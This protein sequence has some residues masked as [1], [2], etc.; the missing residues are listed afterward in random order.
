MKLNSNSSRPPLMKRSNSLAKNN[1]ILTQ[2]YANFQ[3]SAQNQNLNTS[4]FHNQQNSRPITSQSNTGA[5][6]GLHKTNRSFLQEKALIQ[7]Q[8]NYMS[9]SQKELLM[10][11]NQPFD[12][13]NQTLT[14]PQNNS[15]YQ[16]NNGLSLPSEKFV[17][18]RDLNLIRPK[19]V[20]QQ[21]RI[22]ILQKKQLIDQQYQAQNEKTLMLENQNATNSVGLNNNIPRRNSYLNSGSQNDQ[23]SIN[24]QSAN[25]TQQQS[26][27][28]KTK[29][30]YYQQPQMEIAQNQISLNNSKNKAKELA[31]PDYRL[32]TSS[33]QALPRV[34]TEK[35]HSSIEEPSIINQQQRQLAPLKSSNEYEFF[36]DKYLDE[37]GGIGD[38]KLSHSSINQQITPK[39]PR[40]T[41]LLQIQAK[42]AVIQEQQTNIYQEDTQRSQSLIQFQIENNEL[43]QVK[44]QNMNKYQEILLELAMLKDE[45]AKELEELEEEVQ[46]NNPYEEIGLSNQ[47]IQ[48]YQWDVRRSDSKSGHKQEKIQMLAINNVSEKQIKAQQNLNQ[49]RITQYEKKTIE[50][51]F[52]KEYLPRSTQQSAFKD[53]SSQS[54]V[55]IIPPEIDEVAS[56]ISTYHNLKNKIQKSLITQQQQLQ[57]QEFEEK[58]KKLKQQTSKVKN[59]LLKKT[60]Q[61][62]MQKLKQKIKEEEDSLK[63]QIK[64]KEALQRQLMRRKIEEQ[65]KVS[66]AHNRPRMIKHFIE[67][68][69]RQVGDITE[70]AKLLGITNG[71]NLYDDNISQT[72]SLLQAQDEA[73]NIEIMRLQNDIQGSKHILKQQEQLMLDQVYQDMLSEK[74]QTYQEAQNFLNYYG[75]DN[76]DSEQNSSQQNSSVNILNVSDQKLNT[77]AK[78]QS[79]IA[80]SDLMMPLDQIDEAQKQTL[81][82]IQFYANEQDILAQKLKEQEKMLQIVMRDI[83]E[84]EK[85]IGY[86]YG[87]RLNHQRDQVNQS[88]IA[89]K[90]GMSDLSGMIIEEEGQE[91]YCQQMNPTSQTHQNLNFMEDHQIY[92]EQTSI[93]GFPQNDVAFQLEEQSYTQTTNQQTSH[94]IIEQE[95]Q[96]METSQIQSQDDFSICDQFQ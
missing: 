94:K 44:M 69:K 34:K 72:D 1:H 93:I 62:K 5:G 32:Q 29:A 16:F 27:I 61:V 55:A 41:D 51:H 60:E 38:S 11:A 12:S 4:N 77:N 74:Y 80:Q 45:T 71:N 84:R 64:K 23:N 46:Q 86:V 15:F 73:T 39:P 43:A 20:E 58:Q 14:Q 33:S 81:A 90:Q 52:K 7:Q 85:F 31:I 28:E 17:K 25:K 68:N 35:Q 87:D 8:F 67:E 36:F 2:E 92:N 19:S 49:K 48:E 6:V 50:Q 83:Q 88:G 42:P 96:L 30:L 63:N 21:A 24:S 13:K 37:T 82:E 95:N 56:K 75:Y 89:G 47:K 3:I 70:K 91:E 53:S 18:Q 78:F 65:E 57:Q 10:L 76:G 66:K 26:S 40:D 22:R 79:Q 54:S 59:D 9:G